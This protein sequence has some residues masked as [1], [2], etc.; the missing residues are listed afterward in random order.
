MAGVNSEIFSNVVDSMI[1][2]CNSRRLQIVLRLWLYKF[3]KLNQWHSQL[4]YCWQQVMNSIASAGDNSSKAQNLPRQ[5]H[6]T[7]SDF[8]IRNRR[9]QSACHS[10]SSSSGSSSS[11]STSSNIQHF[12]KRSFD[13]CVGDQDNNLK[14]DG[15]TCDIPRRSNIHE[16]KET[17]IT[18]VHDEINGINYWQADDLP[19]SVSSTA[20]SV[21]TTSRNTSSM[22]VRSNRMLPLEVRRIDHLEVR[23]R[24]SETV[25]PLLT[26][27]ND[28]REEY[29]AQ[30]EYD[31]R[32]RRLKRWKFEIWKAAHLKN[33][34][35]TLKPGEF[36][37]SDTEWRGS[38]TSSFLIDNL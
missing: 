17:C 31:D 15:D 30:R 3:V 23:N 25:N 26:Q 4:S 1:T 33:W 6:T 5:T 14:N 21:S 32:V 36:G 12:K 20:A 2:V 34:K 9:F 10:S 8:Q 29:Q 7:N 13:E 18:A 28:E 19:Q 37:E 27:L 38:L 24:R 35:L 16:D 22:P 11:T